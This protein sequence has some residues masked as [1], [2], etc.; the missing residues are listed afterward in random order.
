MV[1]K[2]CGN[3]LKDNAIICNSCKTLTGSNGDTVK[4]IKHRYKNIRADIKYGDGEN[5]TDRISNAMSNRLE[6][7]DVK[8]IENKVYSKSVSEDGIIT[9]KIIPAVE[10][11]LCFLAL[12]MPIPMAFVMGLM[13]KGIDKSCGRRVLKFVFIK[14]ALKIGIEIFAGIISIGDY[15]SLEELNL[16]EII[17]YLMR[18]PK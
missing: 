7:I 17:E 14:L 15:L 4:K 9:I 3:V 6:N 16:G 12:I 11:F 8:D 18:T 1:C 13:L 5:T 10:K 2:A